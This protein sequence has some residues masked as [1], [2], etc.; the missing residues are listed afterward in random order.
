MKKNLLLTVAL[1]TALTASAQRQWVSQATLIPTAGTTT[2]SA[3]DIKVV[4]KDNVWAWFRSSA[5]GTN[6]RQYS[7]TT[8]GGN[9]WKPK[10]LTAT[11]L[12]ITNLEIANMSVIDSAY[13]FAALY[14]P[15]A[16]VTNQGI[17]KT[18]NGGLSWTKSTVG[19]FTTGTSFVN[20][21]HFWDKAKGVCMGDPA[22]GGFEI[23]TTADTV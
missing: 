12:T 17:Y 1:G 16:T 2:K 9:T 7:Y 4:D 13:A 21:V 3:T 8:N 23:Y 5:T 11:G 18:V 14:P 19:K 15:A 10:T 22:N 6:L 20:W